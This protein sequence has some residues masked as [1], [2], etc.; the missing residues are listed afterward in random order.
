MSGGVGL[1]L[2]SID[3]GSTGCVAIVATSREEASQI[4]HVKNITNINPHDWNEQPVQIGAH[5]KG[6]GVGGE[7]ESKPFEP[8][9]MDGLI[10]NIEWAE[11]LPVHNEALKCVKEEVLP[12][13][14]MEDT[15]NTNTT[16][17]TDTSKR[18]QLEAKRGQLLK[19]GAS[20]EELSFVNHQIYM[21]ISNEFVDPWSMEAPA[22]EAPATEAPA[23]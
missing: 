20:R 22:T 15:M 7:W 18:K 10:K 11:V 12:V 19:S 8:Q 16:D 1:F 4:L 13:T 9:D 6:S 23:K 14:G 2:Y 5:I 17:T 3:F 21:A